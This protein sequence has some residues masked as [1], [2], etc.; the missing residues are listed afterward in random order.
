M[1]K[2][3]HIQSA[4]ST[5]HQSVRQQASV[6]TKRS[7]TFSCILKETL[8]IK[9]T[10]FS[11][12]KQILVVSLHEGLFDSVAVHLQCQHSTQKRLFQI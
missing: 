2:K 12:S 10:V 3:E 5:L 6:Q 1:E 9:P 11:L 4:L 7:C 8:Q